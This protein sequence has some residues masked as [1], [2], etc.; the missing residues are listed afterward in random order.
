MLVTSRSSKL[1]RFQIRSIS[2]F[3]TKSNQWITNQRWYLCQRINHKML[4]CS[5]IHK[6]LLYILHQPISAIYIKSLRSKIIL[7][8]YALPPPIPPANFTK[9]Q[10]MYITFGQ[11]VN[12]T[13]TNKSISE[14]HK[15]RNW[16]SG[17]QRHS[18]TSNL[19]SVRKIYQ[20]ALLLHRYYSKIYVTIAGKS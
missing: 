7:K 17:L 16:V 2:K 11:N 1:H 9:Q 3:S 14:G 20:T 10:K 13:P 6:L 19:T 15:P 4:T 8:L 12:F 18:Q 5:C